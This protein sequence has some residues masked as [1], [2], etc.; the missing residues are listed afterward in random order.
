MSMPF[1]LVL[2]RHGQSEA[3]VRQKA[4]KRGDNSLF[5]DDLVTVP[6]NSWRLTA[7]GAQQAQIAGV[8]LQQLVPGGL[9]SRQILSPFMRTR[10]T[11]A[12]LNMPLDSWEENRIIRERSWGEIDGLSIEEFEEKYPQNALYKEKDPIYWC[13]PA[14]ESLASVIEN[15]SSNFLRSLERDSSNSTILAVTH[16][17]F[18]VA[19]RMLIEGWS[20]ERFHEVELDEEQK[21]RNCMMIHYSRRNPHKRGEYTDSFSWVRL[22]YPSVEENRVIEGEWKPITRPEPITNE[23]LF[24]LVESQ[25]RRLVEADSIKANH[26]NPIDIPVSS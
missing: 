12:N 9:F 4:S 11:A 8:Y 17:E 21:I 2:I 16:G 10:E 26:T 1:D 6:D 15:R 14:G 25:E 22:S 13:P 5:T 18:I 23:D 3:N 20:D 7:L 24:A 19:T